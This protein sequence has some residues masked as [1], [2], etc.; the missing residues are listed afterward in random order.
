MVVNSGSVAHKVSVQTG[1]S[2][3]D[4]VQITEGLNGRETVITSGAYGL[5]DGTKVTIGKPGS[6][7]DEK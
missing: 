3:G 2:D 4:D 6:E 1:I 7:G 5:D